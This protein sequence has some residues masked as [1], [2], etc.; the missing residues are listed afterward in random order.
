M[1]ALLQLLMVGSCWL[2]VSGC[3]RARVFEDN[4]DLKDNVWRL[5]EKLTFDFPI[6]DTVQR[7]TVYLNIRNAPFYPFYNLFV[8]LTITGPDER[9]LSRKLHEMELLD[10]QSG[11]PLGKGTGD[12]FDHQFVALRHVRFPKAGTYHAEAEQYM[13][14]PMLDGIMSVGLRVA[15]EEPA[16]AAK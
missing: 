14:Q 8:K 12:I 7:H 16:A 5:R 4:T 9:V 1:R 6:Q 3:D 15:R 13:R 10:A 2:L 11:E